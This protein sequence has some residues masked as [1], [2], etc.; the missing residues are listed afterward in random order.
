MTYRH[1]PRPRVHLSNGR[2]RIVHTV[3]DPKG[4]AEAEETAHTATYCGQTYASLPGKHQHFVYHFDQL[5]KLLKDDSG[6]EVCLECMV[7]EN[8][9]SDLGGNPNTKVEWHEWDREY[10]GGV[11]G[12]G[13]NFHHPRRDS[14]VAWVKGFEWLHAD[15]DRIIVWCIKPDGVCTAEYISAMKRVVEAHLLAKQVPRLFIGND[16][17]AWVNG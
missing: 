2:Q 4:S 8:L 7:S 14:P 11:S 9:R 10:G 5:S 17:T 6:C 12:H 3:T 16:V 15:P 13:V 1:G